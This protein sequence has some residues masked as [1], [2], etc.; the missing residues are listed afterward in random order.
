MKTWYCES[1]KVD[2]T[3][4]LEVEFRDKTLHYEKRC[5]KCTKCRGYIKK[6]DIKDYIITK[7]LPKKHKQRSLF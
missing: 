3:K 5:E 1:C 4:I 6:K 2:N 7:G